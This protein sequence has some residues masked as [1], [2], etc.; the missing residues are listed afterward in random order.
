MQVADACSFCAEDA[1]HGPFGVIHVCDRCARNV[2]LVAKQGDADIW[3]PAS[4][5]YKGLIS[6][7]PDELLSELKAK[8]A[9]Q[10]SEDDAHSHDSLADA[11]LAMGLYDEAVG[12]AATALNAAR[13]RTV[14]VAALRKLL[15]P[16][17]LKSDGFARLRHRV[18][19]IP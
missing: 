1:V 11:Y 8:V 12:E 13:T 15:S 6:A 9:N 18:R 4:P 14:L 17:L 3:S 16:P 7:N 19:R 10:I 2:G 5:H